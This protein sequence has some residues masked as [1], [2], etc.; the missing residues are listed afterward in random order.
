MAVSIPTEYLPRPEGHVAYDLCGDG[1]L[2]LCIPGMGDIRST[3]RHLTPYLVEAGYSVATVDLR[4][5]GDSD[6]TFSA[7][8][9]EAAADDILA[10]L[11]HLHRP[12]VIVGNSMGA[13]AA[14][15]AAARAPKSVSGLVLLGPFVR[16]PPTG[17][18]AKALMRVAMAPW[19]ARQVW[20]MYLPNLYA[21]TR[22]PD[23]A[24]HRAAI[25]K[26]MA[27]PG[28]TEAFSRTTR[29]S[30]E[31][32]EAALPDVHTPTLV[33]MGD[34]DPD[35]PDPRAEARWVADALGGEVLIVPETGHYPQSQR[36]EVVGPAVVDFVHRALRSD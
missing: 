5:H 12:A 13:A 17:A 16:N 27:A 2:V 9:D 36:P 18:V 31:P 32:A 19:W 35:F 22:G 10:L 29:T 1:P 26:A 11:D 25:M 8:D 24:E 34:R 23:F 28:H 33:V 14:V 15:I 4:G 30:H 3:Y 7:Y 21:G 20:R 6:A